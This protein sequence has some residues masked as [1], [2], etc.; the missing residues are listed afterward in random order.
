MKNIIHLTSN[1]KFDEIKKPG[2]LYGKTNPDNFH[3]GMNKKLKQIIR[4]KD[5]LVGLPEGFE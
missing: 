2:I 3:L 1:K 4:F 5:H